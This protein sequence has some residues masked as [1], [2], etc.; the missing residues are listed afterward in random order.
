[1]ALSFALLLIAT[2]LALLMFGLF[3]FYAWLPFFYGLFGFDIGFL[4][5]NRLFGY[6][7]SAPVV[8]G[9]I[10]AVVLA[11]A[12]YFL[13]P[14]RRIVIGYL[15]GSLVALSLLGLDRTSGGIF[16]AVIA[17]CAGVPGAMLAAKYFD[18]F[19]IATSAYGGGALCVFGGQWLLSQ[20]GASAAASGT[21][22]LATLALTAI[23]ARFQ[24]RHMHSWTPAPL[25]RHAEPAAEPRERTR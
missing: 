8:I 10:L 24:L 7:G 3:L 6:G 4:L 20:F 18:H 2:G 14:Y 23:G 1:M 21:Q 17:V 15:G 19:V 16:A 13:E 22:L 25:L 5:G 11:A 12:T 9:L